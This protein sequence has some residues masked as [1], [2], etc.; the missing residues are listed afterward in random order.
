MRGDDRQRRFI[1]KVLCWHN[2]LYGT[3][4]KVVDRCEQVHPELCERERWDWVCKTEKGKEGAIEVKRLTHQEKHK[5]NALL[6][7][8]RDE[9]GTNPPPQLRGTYHLLLDVDDSFLTQ[10]ATTKS[11]SVRELTNAFRA[12]ISSVGPTL[13][14][15]QSHDLR[16]ELQ[17]QL[18]PGALTGLY[19]AGL[20]RLTKDGS[21]IYVDIQTGG[22]APAGVLSDEDLRR[23][24]ALVR[25]ANSQL[26][27]AKTM[28][29]T[30]TFLITPDLLYHLAA[31]P[32]TIKNTFHMLS[33]DCHCNI[34]YV[35]HVK[36]F[37]TPVK[38]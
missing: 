6:K 5:G 26:L 30:E 4:F 14:E 25:K 29:I 2:Q 17:G 24:E 11:P 9:L 31:F 35:Y 20:T 21:H 1:S 16:N 18:L 37:V 19:A 15:Q 34:D 32:D 8:V 22:F 27:R 28:G 38:P 7:K 13:H 3:D 33:P 12:A 36:R 23:F 10:L